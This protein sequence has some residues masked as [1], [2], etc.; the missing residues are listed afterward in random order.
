MLWANSGSCKATVYFQHFP[1]KTKSRHFAGWQ[2]VSSTSI[3]PCSLWPTAT[4]TCAQ[5]GVFHGPP[6]AERDYKIARSGS[7]QKNK[8][9]RMVKTGKRNRTEWTTFLKVFLTLLRSRFAVISQRHERR[10]GAFFIVRIFFSF[11]SPTLFLLTLRFNMEYASA[12]YC[13]HS[14]SFRRRVLG[15]VRAKLA[16]RFFLRGAKR[17]QRVKLCSEF[18]TERQ[19]NRGKSVIVR[20]VKQKTA[21]TSQF[22]WAPGVWFCVQL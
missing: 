14:F 19:W 6:Y 12:G 15:A 2:C 7:L 21:R 5:D 3:A 8:K 4:Y 13:K 1:D 18:W 10:M 11:R 9:Y 22:P 20:L 16:R 17:G